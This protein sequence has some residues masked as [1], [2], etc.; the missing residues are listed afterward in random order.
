MSRE[1]R[2]YAPVSLTITGSCKN[3]SSRRIRSLLRCQLMSANH[4]HR[5]FRVGGDVLADRA[6]YKACEAAVT[7][8]ADHQQVGV[9][10]LLD[11]HLRRST[12]L[13]VRLNEHRWIL[14]EFLGDDLDEVIGGAL[15]RVR[16]VPL[17]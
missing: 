2:R 15:A 1:S 9:R 5:A 10:R 16:H 3:R 11:E 8:A 17:R 7:A 12:L 4:G 13:D 6:E 14:A